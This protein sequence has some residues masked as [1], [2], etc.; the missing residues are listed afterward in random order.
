MEI[1]ARSRQK[2][3]NHCVL[4]K[5]RCDRRSPVCS[6]CA[7]K[8]VACTYAKT[9]VAG[10]HDLGGN[11]VPTPSLGSAMAVN[12][13]RSPTSNPSSEFNYLET[14][15]IPSQAFATDTVI[16]S[17]R[18]YE[19]EIMIDPFLNLMEVNATLSQDQWIIPGAETASAIDRP[20]SPADKETMD[21]YE[22]MVEL[23]V[24]PPTTAL[25]LHRHHIPAM[26]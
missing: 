14:L 15:P 16:D 7:E 10:R 25:P 18:A 4:I 12:S 5:R 21:S 6:R 3:C 17:F 22:G 9:R 8:G 1:R 13:T 19:N 24:S 11:G 26:R 23:C 20:G 2:N